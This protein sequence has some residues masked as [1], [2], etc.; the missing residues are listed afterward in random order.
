MQDTNTVFRKPIRPWQMLANHAYAQ[1]ADRPIICNLCDTCCRD[2]LAHHV[3]SCCRLSSKLRSSAM[4][5]R[6]AARCKCMHAKSTAT[7]TS[8]Q[9]R[10]T[11]APLFSSA[12]PLRGM[13]SKQIHAPFHFYFRN[14][15]QIMC[16]RY[17]T[18]GCQRG[19]CNKASCA[20]V[21]RDI[22]PSQKRKDAL[23]NRSSLPARKH[24]KIPHRTPPLSFMRRTPSHLWMPRQRSIT[25]V[26]IHLTVYLCGCV[27]N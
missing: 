15:H 2:F 24:A 22:C 21:T 7:F 4:Q 10:K 18:R 26:Y 12:P 1:P 17:R 23:L 11:T 16:T 6:R 25:L 20:P 13:H 8:I 5:P 27:S 19:Y 14:R 3:E 9:T